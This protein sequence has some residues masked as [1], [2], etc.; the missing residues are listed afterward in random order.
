MGFPPL[1]FVL[2]KYHYSQKMISFAKHQQRP[3]QLYATELL[4]GNHMFH[5]FFL[6]ASGIPDRQLKDYIELL[7]DNSSLQNYQLPTPAG[8][9]PPGRHRP[10]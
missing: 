4:L 2:R 10:D 9:V 3:Y 6:R 5:W 7:L 8:S 1:Y